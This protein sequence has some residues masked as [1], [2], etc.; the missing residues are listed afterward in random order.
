VLLLDG[1]VGGVWHQKRSG[2]RVTITV[3]PLGR[4]TK[5]HRAGLEVEV[6]RIGA[7]VQAQPDLTVGPVTV[8]AHA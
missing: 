4:L 1:V 2:R 5:A 7:I 6:E 8:G 3:E